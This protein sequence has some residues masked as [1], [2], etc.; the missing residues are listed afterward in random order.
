M[1]L[2]L[3]TPP[4]IDPGASLTQLIQSVQPVHKKQILG[5]FT[6]KKMEDRISQ[7]TWYE[8]VTYRDEL[9]VA[10]I[11]KSNIIS[12]AIPKMK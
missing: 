12:S 8:N 10:M 9:K 7:R 4:T 11:Q 5:H 6:H 2:P 1:P 3:Y